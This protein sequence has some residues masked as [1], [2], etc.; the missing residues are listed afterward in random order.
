IFIAYYAF[1]RRLP[2]FKTGA[3]CEWDEL[4]E[5][6]K[7]AASVV[8]PEDQ[9]KALNQS[10]NW[11]LERWTD[12]VMEGVRAKAYKKIGDDARARLS[13]SLYES[14]RSQLISAESYEY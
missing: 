14:G 9:A 4:N 12:L 11:L 8:T 10:T 1:P 2:F 6:Y 3:P 7:F 13:Y 5:E